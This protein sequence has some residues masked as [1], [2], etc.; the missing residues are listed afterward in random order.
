MTFAE[1]NSRFLEV[2]E[3]LGLALVMLVLI[4]GVSIWVWSHY[5]SG[6]G[7]GRISGHAQGEGM[8][9]TRRIQVVVKRHV[10]KGSSATKV[11][12]HFRGTGKVIPLNPSQARLIADALDKA[13]AWARSAP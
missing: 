5:V 9:F 10:G 2:R 8:R 6:Q 13:A 7:V 11:E 4:V 12:L 3:I 1:L